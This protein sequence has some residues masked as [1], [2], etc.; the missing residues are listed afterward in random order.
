MKQ[1]NQ[2]IYICCGY[3]GPCYPVR[4]EWMFEKI[5]QLWV[6]LDSVTYI[7]VKKL[8]YQQ[9]Y[10]VV[11]GTYWLDMLK[12]LRNPGYYSIIKSIILYTSLEFQNTKYIRLNY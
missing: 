12:W 2:D 4:N 3:D 1:Y 5:A 11:R 6:R 7:L 9:G 10:I 8:L